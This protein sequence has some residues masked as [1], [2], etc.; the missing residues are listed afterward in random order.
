LPNRHSK[1]PLVDQTLKE[2]A[3][4]TTRMT[5]N[6]NKWNAIKVKL[7]VR[8]EILYTPATHIPMPW[9][10]LPV[11]DNRAFEVVN[12]EQITSPCRRRLNMASHAIVKDASGDV[13]AEQIEHWVIAVR[14]GNDPLAAEIILYAPHKGAGQTHPWRAIA[15][16]T[17]FCDE[18]AAN[19]VAQEACQ[20]L[21]RLPGREREQQ[22]GL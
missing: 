17:R 22:S 2:I 9:N 3:L 21:N 20:R 12:V 13:L 6:T 10:Y 16:E 5:I 11:R 7:S 4:E 14:D 19:R 1:V 18:D 15:L 8:G